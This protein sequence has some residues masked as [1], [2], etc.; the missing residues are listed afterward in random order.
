MAIQRQYPHVIEVRELP[1]QK[2]LRILFDRIYDQV[3][4]NISTN[5]TIAQLQS[6]IQVDEAAFVEFKRQTEAN[7]LG[8]VGQTL[9]AV[10]GTPPGSPPPAGDEGAGASGCS[11]AGTTGHVDPGLARDA[12][13]AGMIV[14]GT[15]FEY[16][17]LKDVTVDLATR[18]ANAVELLNRMIWHLN[19]QGFVAGRQKNPSGAISNDKIAIVIQGTPRAYDVFRSFDTFTSPM[20]TQMLEVF[21]ANLQTS[22]GTPD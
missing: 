10:G 14:C 8:Q 9:T 3:D 19:T 12:T 11:Q 20:Q 1:I 7:A 22:G 16:P 13:T 4:A 6:Q 17:A 15:G 5:E 2:A 21:P 18:L